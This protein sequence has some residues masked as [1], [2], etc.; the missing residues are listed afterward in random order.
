MKPF[1]RFLQNCTDVK[2]ARKVLGERCQRK[3]LFSGSQMGNH[4]LQ[5]KLAIFSSHFL[6]ALF[7][8]RSINVTIETLWLETFVTECFSFHFCLF[9][10]R[11]I[12]VQYFGF[13]F[14]NSNLQSASSRFSAF[15][16]VLNRRHGNI[17]FTKI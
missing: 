13:S 8:F 16:F 6:K 10:L 7:I 14:S 15:E 5:E 3:N 4:Q 2:I 17:D 12:I 1:L 11:Y 9:C